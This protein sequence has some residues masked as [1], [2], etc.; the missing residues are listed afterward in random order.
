MPVVLAG[1]EIG[2]RPNVLMAGWI[3]RVNL[4]PL[5]FQEIEA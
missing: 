5:L 4:D 1:T 2:G 3:S